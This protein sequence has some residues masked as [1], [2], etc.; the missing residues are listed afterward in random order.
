VVRKLEIDGR[1]FGTIQLALEQGIEP[2]NMAMG[3]M[4]GVALLLLKAQEYNLP[5]HLRFG[6]WRQ[7][8]GSQIERILLWIWGGRTS[9]Y[10]KQLIAHVCKAQ[11]PLEA[12]LRR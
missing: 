5:I 4:A 7:L 9:K 2:K 3:A 11:R 1:I 8:D 6:D 12:L 10:S